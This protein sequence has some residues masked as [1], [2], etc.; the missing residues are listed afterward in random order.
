V[1]SSYLSGSY[2]G[3]TVRSKAAAHMPG[4]ST[5]HLISNKSRLAGLC[6]RVTRYL[7]VSSSS[8]HLTCPLSSIN[9]RVRHEHITSG[10]L[11]DQD[12]NVTG[13]PAQD[14][15]EWNAEL[16]S[17]PYAAH[18]AR[19]RSSEA[20]ETRGWEMLLLSYGRGKPR[21]NKMT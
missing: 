3:R 1:G 12:E 8:N 2:T 20:P 7:E 15:D 16:D 14:A 4:L 21:L 5:I 13:S 11:E 19:G 6:V 9:G 10:W 18:S 17:N